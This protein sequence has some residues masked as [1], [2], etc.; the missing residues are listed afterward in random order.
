MLAWRA[1]VHNQLGIIVLH[2]LEKSQIFVSG[3]LSLEL[4]VIIL[5]KPRNK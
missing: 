2:L 3:N 5:F 4:N 1:T